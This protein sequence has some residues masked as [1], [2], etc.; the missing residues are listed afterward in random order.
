LVL[1]RLLGPIEVH[2]DDGRVLT[3]RRR[4]ER[5]LL[6]V[7]LLD[8][9]RAIPVDRLGELL[10]DGAPPEQFR[11]TLRTYAARIRALVALAGADRHGVMLKAKDGG[12]VLDIDAG[13]V[14]I[15]R[16]RQ[17]VDQA[18]GTADPGRRDRV[19]RDA[20]ALWHGPPL[21]Q[22]ASPWLRHRLC[23]DLE[24]LHQRA[25]EESMAVG[26]ALGH[27]RELLPELAR[28]TIEQP[29]HERLVALHMLALHQAGRTADALDLYDRTRTRLVDE[30]G[31]DPGAEL[32]QT[33]CAI[34]RGDP[35]TPPQSPARADPV[36]AQLPADLPQFVGRADHLREL[37]R[38]LDDAD[39]SATVVSTISG[40]AGV[41]KT[42]LA[43]HWA[44]RVRHRFPDGQLYADLRGFDPA[45]APTPPA[46]VIRRFLEGLHVAPPE[47][48]TEPEAQV[49]LYRSLLADRRVLVLLD[50]ARD[51]D[52]VRPLLPGAS[53]CL[54]IVTSRRQLT[55]LIATNDVRP[56][57][58]DL[59]TMPEAGE[60]LATRL[61]AGRTNA[62][63]AATCELIELG[64][65][66]PLA[67][68]IVAAGAATQ[69]TLP[70]HAVAARLRAARDALDPIKGDDDATDLRAV[71]AC[72]YD[73]VSPDAAALFRLLGLNP[74]PDISTTAAASL[75]GIRPAQVEPLLTEL[76]RA[77]LLTETIPGRYTTHDLLRAYATA[78]THVH[79][80]DDDRRAALHRLLDHYLHTAHTV[81]R[82]LNPQPD[83]FPLGT[84][85][86]GTTPEALTDRA[87]ALAWFATEQHTLL[88]ANRQAAA[89]AFDSH[90]WQLAWNLVCLFNLPGDQRDWA[91]TR[92]AALDSTQRLARQTGRTVAH[93]YLTRT[94]ADPDAAIARLWSTLRR[95]ADAD[96]HAGQA[97]THMDIACAFERHGR[98]AEALDHAQ[99][100]VH[101]YRTSGDRDGEVR[102]L[103]ATGWYHML[104]GDHQQAFACCTQAITLY[105]AELDNPPG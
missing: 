75:A 15:H 19:L 91:T 103:N 77:N 9:G 64:A 60:L 26:L 35:A 18:T 67:L 95:F 28:L 38:R 31:L 1:F 99:Q 87:Q 105:Q 104:L 21:E 52:Q 92:A 17:L 73:T 37:D 94:P 54:A 66:L 2:A 16:F 101:R 56:I 36:P 97:A 24:E 4:Q 81:N 80:R 44:H 40:T 69:P 79:D 86:P 83:P 32:R 82:L 41:G 65:R 12:Y 45:G 93:R 71:F 53:G 47:L 14:D 25:V 23:T 55:G 5:C 78:Q 30:L 46:H 70:L 13:L 57:T 62:E 98:Y 11:Q 33:H 90:T 10:W 89:S 22:A 96:D 39:G 61:G 59:L 68:T 58:L 27:H 29:L 8:A 63:P 6:A 49:V 7:L 85:Q 3:L 20:L 74:G 50:N 48:P 102:T 100:A 43:V 88:A 72:S 76:T 34:L 42:A 84:A 51:S